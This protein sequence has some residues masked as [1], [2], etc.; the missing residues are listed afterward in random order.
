MN[1][2][3]HFSIEKHTCRHVIR[4]RDMN[5][6]HLTSQY[7]TGSPYSGTERVP[8]SAFFVILVPD[9]PDAGQS[10]MHA[11]TKTLRP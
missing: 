2:F 4:Y 10:G 7:R 1:K 8:A 3:Y 5:N 6:T 9:C 11:F